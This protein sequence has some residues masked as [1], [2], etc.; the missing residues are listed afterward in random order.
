MDKSPD[1]QAASTNGLLWV[2][3]VLVNNLDDSAVVFVGR[4]ARLFNHWRNFD[5]IFPLDAQPH[6]NGSGDEH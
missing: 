6:G 3:S 1:C 4:V 2:N 5:Q